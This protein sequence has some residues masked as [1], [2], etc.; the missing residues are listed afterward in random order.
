[1]LNG[2]LKEDFN[3]KDRLHLLKMATF[4]PT[5][6]MVSDVNNTNSNI[7][8]PDE[9]EWLDYQLNHPSAYDD[10]NDEW[11]SHFQRVEQIATTLEPTVD[12]YQDYPNED[13]KSQADGH[14]IF[15]RFAPGTSSYNIDAFQMSAW[16][17]NALGNV[18][19]NSKVGSDQLR[20]RMAYAMSQLL[21]V[22]STIFPL[23]GRTEGLAFYY[24][25]L[26]E[27][28]FGNYETL[29]QNVLRSPAMGVF[30]SSVMNQKASLS[31]NTRPDEN[32]A[33][34]F[35]QLFTI[36][37]YELE[38]DG[39]IKIDSAG[40]SIPTYTQD[41]IV[42]M[43]KVLTGWNLFLYPNWGRLG[44]GYG[45]YQHLMEFY[46]E[47]H[48]DELDEFYTDD[49][50]PG[51][52]TLFK[53]KAW[54]ASLELNA[55]DEILDGSGSQ[56]NSG[57]DA[58]IKVMFNHPNV[59]PFVSRHLIKHFVTS[60][61]TP[62]YIERIATVFNDDGSGVRGNLKAVLRAILLDHEAY[63]QSIEV[64]GRVKE[65]LLVLT[66]FLRAME[67][68]PWP[69]TESKMLLHE[70]NPK[71]LQKMYSFR[72]PQDK[73]NQA[74]L[75]A[76]DVFN[77]Y[78]RDFIPP[79]EDVMMNGLTSQESE[80]INDNFFP[81]FQNQLDL[82]ISNYNNY[83]LKCNDPTNLTGL[84]D[85]PEMKYH[86]PNF[87]I[88]LEKSLSVLIKG[89]GK[90]SG[91]LIDVNGSDFNDDGLFTKAVED[92][93]DWYEGNLLFAPL[94]PNFR[95]AFIEL[96]VHGLDHRTSLRQEDMGQAIALRV[97]HNSLLLVV[98]SPD[99]MVEAGTVPDVTPP[100]IE[101]I[102]SPQLNL[103]I[104][105]TYVES[106]FQASDNVFGDMQSKV[107]ITGDVNTS[108]A[109]TYEIIYSVV[110]IAGNVSEAVKRTIVV[111]AE[112]T[113]NPSLYWWSGADNIGNGFYQNWLGQFMPFE[114]GWIYHLEF[115][116]VYVVESDLQGLWMWMQDEGWL[117]SSSTI[118][119]F[120]WSN[121]GPTWLY[122]LDAGENNFFYDYELKSFRIVSR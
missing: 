99:F 20:Q 22:S 80:I 16:W 115:G 89:L 79:D 83:R 104:G 48:E 6:Q 26:A 122:F 94:N 44:K 43:A 91:L 28:A 105:D 27:N 64:G 14:R 113:E 29:L 36:G 90:E 50:D 102:G 55:S 57:L 54:E 63:N 87:I 65:P 116:W 47:K 68:R 52:I 73:L 107:T 7:D 9:I 46:P 82:I 24:D 93:F 78:D 59:G 40:K 12:F 2:Q 70:S 92:L 81:N 30:L 33:R 62:G 112:V 72:S 95:S 61:P 96:C 23:N 56:T 3:L 103:K 84:D 58:A 85:A 76:F 120:I 19:L 25:I 75:R 32:L 97:V 15:N 10:S 41:D 21:V 110:D 38:L 17:D 67:V 39:S 49:Q 98:T 74:A 106:G 42:E 118:W 71:Y 109:G 114:S 8:V 35:M 108:K 86:W 51:I 101:L 121:D 1:M 45:S 53:G 77:F 60:N 88:N 5:A 34:E 13:R 4:G 37:P 69:K 31:K 119:P 117:W 11:L 100:E 66:Q 111:A 18:D